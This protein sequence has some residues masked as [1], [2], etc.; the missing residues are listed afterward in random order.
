MKGIT[1]FTPV[2]QKCVSFCFRCLKEHDDFSNKTQAFITYWKKWWFPLQRWGCSGYYSVLQTSCLRLA[3]I[4]QGRKHLTVQYFLAIIECVFVMVD[5]SQELWNTVLNWLNDAQRYYE[6]LE[7]QPVWSVQQR[8]RRRRT[9]DFW[10]KW[11]WFRRDDGFKR[12]AYLTV[13]LQCAWSSVWG[14]GGKGKV[15]RAV[16][17]FGIANIEA[18]GDVLSGTAVYCAEGKEMSHPNYWPVNSDQEWVDFPRGDSNAMFRHLKL[19]IMVTGLLLQK[20]SSD[21]SFPAEYQI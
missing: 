17:G 8:P 1:A 19:L 15:K 6:V 20:G 21:F 12:L 4:T 2:S 5:P 18:E 9:D 13:C 7:R 3:I 14:T 16:S 10:R 11:R